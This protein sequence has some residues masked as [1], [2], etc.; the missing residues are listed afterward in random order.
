[1]TFHAPINL[2]SY[3]GVFGDSCILSRA[4]VI[5]QLGGPLT[6]YYPR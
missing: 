5:S 1:M 3:L 4:F 6:R 2:D